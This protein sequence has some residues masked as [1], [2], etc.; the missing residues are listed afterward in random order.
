ML[1]KQSIMTNTSHNWR[2]E[3]RKFCKKTRK[4]FERISARKDWDHSKSW[5]W[6]GCSCG[7]HMQDQLEK[8]EKMYRKEINTLIKQLQLQEEAHREERNELEKKHMLE[9]QKSVMG[10]AGV[11]CGELM[12][13]E[14]K[15]KKQL[16]EK[17]LEGEVIN[18]RNI[19]I[20]P[21]AK[22]LV[23]TS[24]IKKVFTKEL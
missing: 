4:E 19:G 13:Q 7:E 8:Q 5:I 23:P 9:K 15:L 11:C 24:H 12:N 20:Q 10:A 3:W 18:D 16:L 22:E 6:I 1:F 14:E 2:E 21:T 17:I